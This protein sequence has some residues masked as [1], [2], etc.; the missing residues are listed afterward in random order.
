MV[1]TIEP[2]LRIVHGRK[3][4]SGGAAARA[5]SASLGRLVAIAARRAPEGNTFHSVVAGYKASQ[6]FQGLKPRT[7]ADYLKLIPRIESNSAICRSRR[8]TTP[9][10]PATFWN[11]ATAWRQ[12]R[13][14]PITVGWL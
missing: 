14:R 8:S 13:V 6:D 1:A 4:K 11:G 10:S 2:E 7:K 3:C 9:A 5:W 12:A